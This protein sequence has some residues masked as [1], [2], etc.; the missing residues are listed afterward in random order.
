MTFHYDA[1]GRLAHVADG[2]GQ[3]LSLAYADSSPG[4][5]IVAAHDSIGRT[6]GY[7]YDG[8]DLVAF[9]NVLG[10]VTRYGYDTV[11]ADSSLKH[12]LAN[13]T[14]PEGHTITCAYYT[15]NSMV[16]HVWR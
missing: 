14:D 5:K 2:T 10:E 1:A 8:D 12:N 4:A 11:Q 6:T 3:S 9:T 13:R 16:D 7:A 15:S